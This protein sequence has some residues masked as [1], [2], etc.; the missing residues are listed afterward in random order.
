[1]LFCSNKFKC[2]FFFPPGCASTFYKKWFYAI[3]NIIAERPH[4]LEYYEEFKINWIEV[5]KK[6][7]EDDYKFIL[8][9]RNPFSRVYSNLKRK[10]LKNNTFENIYNSLQ[11]SKENNLVN[12]F[13]YYKT[14]I[15]EDIENINFKNVIDF[16][17]DKNEHGFTINNSFKPITDLVD[18]RI[19]DNKNLNIFKLEDNN[20]FKNVHNLINL[21]YINVKYKLLNRS[22]YRVTTKFS[23]Q[24]HLLTKIEDNRSIINYSPYYRKNIYNKFKNDFKLFDYDENENINY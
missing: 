22:N 8:L 5:L 24:E 3:H 12:I 18:N 21:E 23:D 1:M 16:I 10:I 2:I 20:T 17:V 14:Y 19:F 13:N 11:K 7:N 15:G 9:V 6:I 4:S